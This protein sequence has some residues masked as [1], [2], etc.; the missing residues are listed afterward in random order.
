MSRIDQ[1]SIHLYKKANGGNPSKHVAKFIVP[2]RGH[3]NFM[4]MFLIFLNGLGAGEGWG[5]GERKAGTVGPVLD[6]HG[7][8]PVDLYQPNNRSSLTVTGYAMEPPTN[9]N[10][11]RLVMIHFGL[12]S[13]VWSSVTLGGGCHL[14]GTFCL[15]C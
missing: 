13:L 11:C 10:R 1:Q 3:E 14:P 5:V 2:A 6:T 15:S 12:F 4:A 8:R 7:D 9:H